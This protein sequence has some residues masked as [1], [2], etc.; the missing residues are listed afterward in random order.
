MYLDILLYKIIEE[1]FVKN[2]NINTFD[3][4]TRISKFVVCFLRKNNLFLADH[5]N[6]SLD[7]FF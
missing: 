4:L 1:F 7:S 6:M 5:F 2:H 3:N